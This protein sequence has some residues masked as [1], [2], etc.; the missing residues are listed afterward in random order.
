MTGSMILKYIIIF[1]RDPFA[2]QVWSL[3]V[4]F[5]PFV[6]FLEIP[7]YAFILA[8]ISKYY[9][10]K[11]GSRPYSSPV[12]PAVSCIVTCYSE[13]Q[14]AAA[15]VRCLAEQLYSGFIEI[16]PVVDGAS[17]NIET[18][19]AV[20]KMAAYA[21]SMP[22]RR[23]VVLPK[24][25]RGGRVSSL[26]AGLAVAS[27]EIV[28]A[29]DGDTSFDNDMVAKA[30]RHFSDKNV[31]GVAGALRVMN[32]RKNL[33]TRIQALEY[34]MSIHAS[35]TGLSEFNVVNNISGAFGIFRKSFLE[36]ISGWSSGTAEDLD[37]TLRIKNYFGRYPALKIVFDPEAIGHTEVPETVLGLFRQRLRWDGDLYYL[38]FRKHSKTFDIRLMGLGNYILQLWTGL[39]FQVFMPLLIIVYMSYICFVYSIHKIIFIFSIV[40]VFYLFVSTVFYFAFVLLVSERAKEDLKLLPVLPIFGLYLFFIRLVNGFAIMWEFITRSHLDSSMAP[41]WVLKKSKF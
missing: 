11:I 5:I 19:N 12:S 40:Y 10:R 35:K 4:T 32:A 34:M 37:I 20:M 15:T 33:L 36:I 22:N 7:V 23:V 41:W 16:I 21:R 14:G 13:G 6:I 18:Y 39:M 24:W 8:G 1:L 2:P 9:L 38:Y 17:A 28:M 3:I 26:N 31:V 27:G 30:A 29:L 25:Q